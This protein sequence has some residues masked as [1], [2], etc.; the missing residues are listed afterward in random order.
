VQQVCHRQA[1]PPKNHFYV[2]R[3]RGGGA[4][5]PVV[6]AHSGVSIAWK[7]STQEQ[8]A[9]VGHAHWSMALRLRL[10]RRLINYFG[11]IAGISEAES[12]FV[13]FEQYAAAHA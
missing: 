5:V 12:G 2:A 9:W 8:L 3:K 4:V 1:I 6:V 10:W 13:V 11:P 7:E